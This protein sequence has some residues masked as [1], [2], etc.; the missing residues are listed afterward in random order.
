M[1]NKEFTALLDTIDHDV[2]AASTTN[3]I[4][5][6]TDSVS[7][8]KGELKYNNWTIYGFVLAFSGLAYFFLIK[9]MTGGI[10]LVQG[11]LLLL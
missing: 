2:E 11:G 1:S 10:G 9:V 3:E 8:Y 5:S 7:N 4:Q 6:T